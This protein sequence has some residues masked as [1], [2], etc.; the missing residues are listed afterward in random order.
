MLDGVRRDQKDE[1]EKLKAELFKA[2]DT[3]EALQRL[4]QGR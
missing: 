4:L 2:Y 1:I 3:E